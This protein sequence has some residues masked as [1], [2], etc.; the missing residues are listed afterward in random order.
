MRIHPVLIK[1][2]VAGITTLK[3]P[4]AHHLLQV[5]RV[6]EGSRLRGFDGDG[7][8]AAGVVKRV[9]DLTLDLI[10]EEPQ[11]PSN[12]AQRQVIAAV[13]LL[14]GDRLSDAVRMLTELGIQEVRPFISRYC[15][16]HVLSANKLGRLRRIAQEAAKQ[17]ERAVVP[18]IHEAVKL[19]QLELEPLTLLA[20]PY[21]TTCMQDI[22]TA[23]VT[24]LMFMTGPEG[25]FSDEEVALLE[26]RGAKPIRLG[27]RILRSDTA[28]VA[29]AAA[30]LLPEAL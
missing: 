17:C 4:Q 27:A 13:A 30:L 28:P 6:Q 19:E 9:D 10:F 11:P 14:K 23:E 21:A 12:E 7:L 5:L 29:L 20:H 15:S 8:E 3:G 25:G 16:V 24:R 26:Q 1:P 18:T 22:I 2:L